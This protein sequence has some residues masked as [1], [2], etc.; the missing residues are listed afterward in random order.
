MTIPRK[1][2]LAF[3]DSANQCL[4]TI[5][6]PSNAPSMDSRNSGLFTTRQHTTIYLRPTPLVRSFLPAT[7][8]AHASFVW[9][10]PKIL[11]PAYAAHKHTHTRT[12][13]QVLGP[14]SPL[15]EPPRRKKREEGKK[16]EREQREICTVLNVDLGSGAVCEAMSAVFFFFRAGTHVAHGSAVVARFWKHVFRTAPRLRRSTTMTGG[17]T[18]RRRRLAPPGTLL[19]LRGLECL[20]CDSG[21][22]CPGSTPPPC[23]G[24]PC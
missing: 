10:P 21:S 19:R 23:S 12:H 11:N 2:P 1:T 9:R 4:N 22:G 3:R 14:S 5:K 24:R 15:P 7:P 20:E 8:G 13:T 16:K 17:V 6:N 18:Q